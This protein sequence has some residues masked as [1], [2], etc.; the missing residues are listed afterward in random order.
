VA[1]GGAA[2][3]LLALGIPIAALFPLRR[4]A[5]HGVVA[6]HVGGAGLLAVLLPRLAA[7]VA[8]LQ[9]SGPPPPPSPGLRAI[10]WSMVAVPL[11]ALLLRR[12]PPIW[13]FR[14]QQG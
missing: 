4:L 1:G 8:R 9:E 12:L 3:H 5:A 10:A 7:L 2:V 11:A 13:F 6:W 14:E